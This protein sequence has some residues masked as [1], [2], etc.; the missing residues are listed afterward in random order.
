MGAMHEKT[1]VLEAILASVVALSIAYYVLESGGALLRYGGPLGWSASIVILVLLIQ[2]FW[3]MRFSPTELREVK[4]NA[5]Y[6]FVINKW[7]G[8]H[9]ALSIVAIILVA[10]HGGVFLASLFEPS[11]LIWLGAAAFFVLVILN[12]SGVVTESKRRSRRFGSLRRMHLLLMVFALALA[13]VHIEGLM[14]GFFIRSIIVG[15][16][17]GL[18]GAL[19]VFVIVPLTVR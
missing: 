9:V 13:L 10:V 16:I 19:A 2:S 3:K 17:A 12:F 11:L 4:A 1:W 8:L 5:R 15:A 18:V 14:S 7:G 6:R